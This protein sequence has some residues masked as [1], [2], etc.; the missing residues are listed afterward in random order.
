MTPKPTTRELLE[1]ALTFADGLKRGNNEPPIPD[2]P[3]VACEATDL[4]AAIRTKLAEGEEEV[5]VVGYKLRSGEYTHSSESRSLEAAR[6]IA[7][8][9]NE[10]EVRIGKDPV[11]YVV[12]LVPVREP[13]REPTHKP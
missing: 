12:A 6:A 2:C 1:R 7:K 4:A 9:W 5:G 10:D 3:C 11:W 8:K 13:E